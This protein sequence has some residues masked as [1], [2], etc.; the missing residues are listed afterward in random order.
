[1]SS[2]SARLATHGASI[3]APLTY[4]DKTS[5]GERPYQV[6]YDQQDPSKPTTNYILKK[7]EL[8]IHDLRPAL[9]DPERRKEISI[10]TTGFAVPEKEIAGTKMKYEDWENE[11]AI[12][13]TYYREVE[14]LLKKVTG[15]S[16]VIIFDHTIRRG[17][18]QGSETPDTPQSRKPVQIVHVDQTPLSGKKRVLRHA[19]EEGL[20]GEHLLR[21]RAQLINVWRPLRGPVLD[22]PLAVA[23]FR[24][25]S[26]DED[27]V[28][29][30]LIY[31][32]EGEPGY[33][34]EGE[35]FA[36]KHSERHQWY[37][38]SEMGPQ[39]VLLLKCWDNTENGG[40]RTPHTAFNDPRYYGKDDVELR[41]SIEIRALVFHP[42]EE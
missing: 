42:P 5:D 10:A 17:E 36:I 18:K 23:D 9:S 39:E 1:M 24:T 33:Q 8:P 15:G 19:K 40:V 2:P 12:R 20:D 3:V 26:V 13:G 14:E 25:L 6:I 41:Q 30:R 22:V 35:T 28:P 11:E 32:P 29:S 4:Y 16:K 34:P 7:P 31:P 27:L 21:G 38:L 37:Y